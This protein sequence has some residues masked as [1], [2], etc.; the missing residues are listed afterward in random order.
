MLVMSALSNDYL[1]DITDKYVLSVN[2][3]YTRTVNSKYNSAD[4]AWRE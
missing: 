1:K 4:G 3:L 2:E